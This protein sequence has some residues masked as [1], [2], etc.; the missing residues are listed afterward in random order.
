MAVA[1]T[2]ILLLLIQVPFSL[3]IIGINAM[4]IHVVLRVYGLQPSIRYFV[5]SLAISDLIKGI[6]TIYDSCYSDWITDLTL[7]QKIVCT[8]GYALFST[9]MLADLFTV[10][11][12]SIDRLIILER[13]FRYKLLVTRWTVRLSCIIIW[14]VAI[15][16]GF[17]PFFIRTEIEF[18][19]CDYFSVAPFH[20]LVIISVF[21]YP[22]LII[23]ILIYA[24]IY[25]LARKHV[26]KVVPLYLYNT[27]TAIRP[28]WKQL[29]STLM[30]FVT[31]IVVL[32]GVA[33]TFF[34]VSYAALCT[35]ISC[36][37]AKETLRTAT[38]I[39][40]T[41]M[42]FTGIANPLIYGL[43]IQEIGNKFKS[44]ACFCCRRVW[45]RPN[46]VEPIINTIHYRVRPVS[47]LL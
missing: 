21:W 6:Y 38:P 28:S 33:P 37:G 15:I 4:I 39:T 43:R 20:S 32:V 7:G 1:V 30:A 3:F 44:M 31:L 11:I 9:L 23:I 26:Q 41:M 13:P 10:T 36:P 2:D 17:V 27:P 16:F 14:G 8:G 25:F 46:Y 45:P 42:V 5:C 47:E 12:L 22:L 29:K 35:K 18:T 19:T 34:I 24:R 40:A